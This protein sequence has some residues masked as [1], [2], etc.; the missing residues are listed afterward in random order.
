MPT[1]PQKTLVILTLV[2][3]I[4]AI[5]VFFTKPAGEKPGIQTT[6]FDL[7]DEPTLGN[8]H[9]NI[10]IVLFEDLKCGN[11]KLFHQ[12][13][14]PTMKAEYIDSKTASFTPI[15]LAFIP[16]S[17]PAGN[18]AYCMYEQSPKYFFAF[19]DYVF[20]H[21]GDEM[22]DWATEDRMIE[23]AQNIDGVKMKSFK[24]CMKEKRYYSR[25]HSNLM[26]ARKLM[27]PV[28]TPAVYINGKLVDPLG[29]STI[30]STMT[31]IK[32]EQ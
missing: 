18:A 30:D 7:R 21:Q 6:S 11:C 12:N 31:I 17:K 13:I 4:V 5:L 22:L 14:F 28:R 3:T 27:K 15:I 9:A 25:L 23:F 29:M 2:I 16:D 8:K 20:Q 10:H 24:R 19:T 1:K 32:E 26:L